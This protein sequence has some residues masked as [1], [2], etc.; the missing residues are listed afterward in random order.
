MLT[1]IFLFCPNEQNPLQ[2]RLI[3]EVIHDAGHVP[4]AVCCVEEYC[5]VS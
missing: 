5:C 3:C 1:K 2:Y 4:G